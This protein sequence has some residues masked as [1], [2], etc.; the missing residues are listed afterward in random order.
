MLSFSYFLKQDGVNLFGEICEHPFF[1]LS[2]RKLGKIFQYK[3]RLV[4]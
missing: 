2:L 4:A 1:Y 3:T